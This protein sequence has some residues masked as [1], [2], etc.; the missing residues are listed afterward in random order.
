MN[1]TLPPLVVAVKLAAEYH[2]HQVDKQGNT[3]LMHL[4]RVAGR[5]ETEIAM[6]AAMLHDL[7]EDTPI[8]LGFIR[9]EFG[10]E[11]ADAVDHLTWRKDQGESYEDFIIRAMQNQLAFGIKLRDVIDHLRQEG[12]ANLSQLLRARYRNAY[13]LMTSFR[14]D[15]V[16]HLPDG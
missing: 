1:K 5:C 13:Q 9:N 8:S 6:T 3:Y 7:V 14:W 10:D 11:I 15:K 12:D 16:K 4:L 2:A